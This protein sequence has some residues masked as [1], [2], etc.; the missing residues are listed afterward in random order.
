MLICQEFPNFPLVLAKKERK[1]PKE[2][3]QYTEAL[4]NTTLSNSEELNGHSKVR[5]GGGKSSKLG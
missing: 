1:K 2:P 4:S 5:K 3:N